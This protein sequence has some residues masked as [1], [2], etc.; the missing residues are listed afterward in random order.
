MY[1]QSYWCCINCINCMDSVSAVL[2]LYQPHWQCINCIDTTP[3]ILTL[4]QLHW[5]CINQ[6]GGSSVKFRFGL[7]I[8]SLPLINAT[9]VLWH[10]FCRMLF[11]VLHLATFN[12]LPSALSWHM[13]GC[14]TGGD[15]PH[16]A[17]VF[18]PTTSFELHLW[19]RALTRR[20]CWSK[21]ILLV[22]SVI[23]STV[24][25]GLLCFIV[26]AL[27]NSG[28]FFLQLVYAPTTTQDISTAFGSLYR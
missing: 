13:C 11:D 23:W 12:V 4:Y 22:H 24:I 15:P 8:W 10:H 2:T 5:R 16:L 20:H 3:T 18:N 21:N 27:K 14:Q 1:Y 28:M 9:C 19:S 26:S 17:R 25:C 6:I 7:H